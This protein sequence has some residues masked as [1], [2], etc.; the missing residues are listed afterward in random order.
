ME[1]DWETAILEQRDL[2]MRPRGRDVKAAPLRNAEAVPMSPTGW[3]VF[4]VGI[5]LAIGG[6]G[7]A[8]TIRIGAV[9]L[10]ITGT[11]GAVL[12]ILALILP[13]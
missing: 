11:F 7:G 5:L 6:W 4:F 1:V 12:A 13:I 10:A 3:T 9:K 2:R 8:V